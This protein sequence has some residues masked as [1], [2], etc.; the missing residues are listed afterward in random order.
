MWDWLERQRKRQRDL[1]NGADADLVRE[2]RRRWKIAYTLFGIS[3][4]LV[5]VQA[6]IRLPDTWHRVMVA[7]TMVLFTVGL[8]LGQ[9]AR[10]EK[11]FLDKPDPKEPPRLW[12]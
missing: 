10:A 2:N 8:L 4:F 1:Q 5:G 9:W 12:K 7:L 6:L 3:F 11:G